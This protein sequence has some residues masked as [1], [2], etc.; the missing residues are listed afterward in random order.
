MALDMVK[1][2][3]TNVLPMIAIGG[4]INWTFSGFLA[5]NFISIQHFFYF[6]VPLAKVPFPLTYRFKA[7]LQRGVELKSLS[8]SWSDHTPFEMIYLLCID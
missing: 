5:S 3:F 1:S 8:A 4:W 7:M 6:S 2:T